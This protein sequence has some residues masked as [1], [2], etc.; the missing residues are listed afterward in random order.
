VTVVW[1]LTSDAWRV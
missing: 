1:H